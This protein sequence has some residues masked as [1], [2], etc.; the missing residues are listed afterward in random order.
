LEGGMEQARESGA[1]PAQVQAQGLVEA[2]TGAVSEKLLGL[3]PFLKDAGKMTARQFARQALTPTAGKVALQE[4]IQEPTEGILN[5]L[6][7]KYVTGANPDEAVWDPQTLA[8]EAVGGGLGGAGLSIPTLAGA[9]IQRQRDVM[10]RRELGLAGRSEQ[11]L[12]AELE[13]FNQGIQQSQ[14]TGG[15]VELVQQTGDPYRN[16]LNL[17]AQNAPPQFQM[18]TSPRTARGLLRSETDSGLGDFAPP[19]GR[20]PIDQF[21]GRTRQAAVPSAE[22]RRAALEAGLTLPQDTGKFASDEPQVAIPPRYAQAPQL[23]SLG[24]TPR[25]AMT[26]S[27]IDEAIMGGRL[28]R[29]TLPPINPQLQQLQDLAESE[30]NAIERFP[31]RDTN[32]RDSLL[33][34]APQV[35]QMLDTRIN[36][37]IGKV[38]DAEVGRLM[39]LRER[40]AKFY[41]D[42]TAY[43]ELT[44]EAIGVARDTRRPA[45]QM[46]AGL[47]QLEQSRQAQFPAGGAAVQPEQPQS[48]QPQG[49]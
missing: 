47:S 15:G 24:T 42:Q 13:A 43:N 30:L 6:S 46:A 21:I 36:N 8:M 20:T 40:L 11:Q 34:A 26:T 9:K 22:D 5:R 41:N 44:A 3:A 35:V 49:D 29:S 14:L 33:G 10:G 1:T 27:P 2:A 45:P 17:S 4:A 39:D 48:I 19:D 31:N 28:Q 12:Q 23:A 37:S 32:R 7:S 38:S 16:Q 18:V 25:T